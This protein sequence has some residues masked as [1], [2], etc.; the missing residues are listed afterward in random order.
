[1][2]DYM[3]LPRRIGSRSRSLYLGL[4]RHLILGALLGIIVFFAIF[5]GSIV[6]INEFYLTED[7]RYFRRHE[8]LVDLEYH[9]ST[10]TDTEGGQDRIAEW[11]RDNPYI[12][13]LAYHPSVEAAPA[14]YIPMEGEPDQ[15]YRMSE[16]SGLQ[17]G[18]TLS[19]EELI[20][21][22][23][24][25]GYYRIATAEGEIVVAFSEYSE[26][27]YYAAAGLS[28]LVLGVLSSLLV[29]MNYVRRIIE[30]IKRVESDITIVSELDMN[31]EILDDGAD[32][33]KRLSENV[34]QMRRRMLEH[35]KS[36][37]E[38]R[39]A[40]NELITSISHDIR[41]PL[42]V[43]MGYIEMMK[44]RD[45][46]E[47]M[48]A[49]ISATESTAMRLKQLSEDMFKYSLAFGD[50][51]GMITMEE[52][53]ALTLF[54]QMLSEHIVLMREMGY[55]VQTIHEGDAMP[56]GS[57]VVTDAQNLMRIVDNIFSNLRKYADPDHP[58]LI[59]VE[60]KGNKMILECQNKVKLDIGGAESNGIGLKT[61]ARLASLVADKFTYGREGDY[62]ACT[63]SL[64]FRQK[65]VL[66]SDVPDFLI[67]E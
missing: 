21:N 28:G 55:D 1:M 20:E 57:V 42:T 40:N 65:S 53:D 48:Q 33:I 10:P 12:F 25:G 64:R 32:E 22:A 35:I 4:L 13:L 8:Y 46:D 59:T 34:D 54:D 67:G 58:I 49:Y 27:Q 63:L 36:E 47:V 45:N 44:E 38:A 56:D 29:M 23:I 19:H 30:R 66:D 41:T 60:V 61:C 43:L 11:V 24:D 39:E 52:Y 7:M 31:Y 51:G 2:T 62:F 9:L 37:Q 14:M 15:S 26:N 17:I 6:A 18:E 16:Y 50:T 5:L 3:E